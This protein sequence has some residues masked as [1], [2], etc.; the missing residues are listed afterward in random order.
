[1]WQ[2]TN[3]RLAAAYAVRLALAGSI[4]HGASSERPDERTRQR[5]WFVR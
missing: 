5:L 3:P 1:V 4:A 2:R